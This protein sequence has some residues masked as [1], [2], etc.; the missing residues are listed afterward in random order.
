MTSKPLC[1]LFL[2]ILALNFLMP[3]DTLATNAEDE[4]SQE[5]APECIPAV[6]GQYCDDADGAFA[7][8]IARCPHMCLR[9]PNDCRHPDAPNCIAY[10]NYCEDTDGPFANIVAHCPHMCE[11]CRP[12]G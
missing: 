10:Y 5:D 6:Y 1:I 7:P 11:R 9:C 12:P 2:S 4:C 8:V 3:E